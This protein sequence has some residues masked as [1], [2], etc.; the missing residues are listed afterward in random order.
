MRRSRTTSFSFACLLAVAAFAGCGGDDGAGPDS[1]ASTGPGPATTVTVEE[2]KQ[3]FAEQTGVELAARDFPGDTTLLQFDD[4]G[5][6]MEVSEAEA[7]FAEEYGNAQIYIVGPSGDVEQ[8][9]D[10][11][12]GE[13]QSEEPVESGGTTYAWSR[14]SRPNRMGTA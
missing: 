12:T 4:D 3:G 14:T 8:I 5:E 1:G 7:A 9:F 10:V 11:V 2:F 13:S 6:A